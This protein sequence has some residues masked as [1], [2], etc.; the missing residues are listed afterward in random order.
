MSLDSTQINIPKLD[1]PLVEANEKDPGAGRAISIPWY[2]LLIALW[3]R[4]GGTTGNASTSVPTGTILPFGGTVAPAGFLL[5]NG[6]AVA[7]TAQPGLFA[8]IGRAYGPGDGSTT[9]NLPNG[10][11]RMFY[12]AGGAI[13]VGAT[14]GSATHNLTINELPPH[15]HNV[16]GANGATAGPPFTVAVGSNVA[17]SGSIATDAT[18]N[19]VPLNWLNPYFAGNW[20]IKT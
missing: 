3:N 11:N 12:G 10:Q 17:Q 15:A 20:I 2:R 4:T 1:T 7:V 8:V 14:G 16:P 18:G 13:A 6:A 5:C 9:F 19:A